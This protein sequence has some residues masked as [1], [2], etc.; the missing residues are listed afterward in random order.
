[1]K[2]KFTVLLLISGAIICSAFQQSSLLKGNYEYQGGVYNG[3]AEGAPV[4][5]KM[6]RAYTDKDFIATVT[7][8]G[9]SPAKYEAGKYTTKEDS[10][11]ETATFNKQTPQL[12]GKTSRFR[13]RFLKNTLI[14][15]GKT[16]GGMIVVEY[17]KKLN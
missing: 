9:F 6:T 13:Y 15:S 16:P 7:Q 2:I 4:G 3:K 8:K 10:C 1:M 11:F 5:Y 17:W 14:L 12:V